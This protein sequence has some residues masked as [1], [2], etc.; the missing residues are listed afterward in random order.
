[1]TETVT[2]KAYTGIAVSHRNASAAHTQDTESDPGLSPIEYKAG[3]GS[4]QVSKEYCG[5]RTL[6]ASTG[7]DLDL[8]AGGLLDGLGQALTFAVVKALEIRADAGNGGN[9]VVGGAAANG[10]LG[11]FA[12]A[13]DKIK[14]PAGGQ[15]LI[16]HPGAGW[17]VAAGTGDL[18]HVANDDAGAAATYT[19]KIVG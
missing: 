3:T 6:A 14:V 5:T 8:A 2:A 10:F 15:A 13:T 17:T 12:D 1:M 4:G 18:L 19:I 11:P 16:A 7:E 9:I